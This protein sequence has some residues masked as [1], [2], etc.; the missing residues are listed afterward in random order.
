MEEI[1]KGSMILKE[2]PKQVGMGPVPC[3]FH[4]EEAGWQPGRRLSLSP[5][6]GEGARGGAHST[7]RCD[8]TSPVRRWPA[9]QAWW[10]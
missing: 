7:P 1:P 8:H 6:L 9:P 3:A 5:A 10:V 2:S 4:P